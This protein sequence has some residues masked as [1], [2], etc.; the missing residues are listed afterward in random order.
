MAL[1]HLYERSCL[2]EEKIVINNRLLDYICSIIEDVIE[3]EFEDEPKNI[4]TI[5]AVNN[6]LNQIN[7]DIT[8]MQMSDLFGEHII[9]KIFD[10]IKSNM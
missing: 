5:I 8:D 10:E 3:S 9:N 1:I 4:N 2:V 6:F 7:F